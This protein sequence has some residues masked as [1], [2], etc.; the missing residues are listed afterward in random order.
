MNDETVE[1]MKSSARPVAKNIWKN[2][3]VPIA[4]IWE[5]KEN[6]H[7]HQPFHREVFSE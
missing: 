7:S 1:T 2:A 5:S 6:A 4:L 3:G